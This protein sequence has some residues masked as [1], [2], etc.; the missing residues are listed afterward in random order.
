MCDTT[1]LRNW[2]YACLAAIFTAVA[3]IVGAAIANG[4]WWLT[5]L[6]PIGMVVAAA[7]TAGAVLLVG[8]AQSA[9]DALCKCTGPRCAGQCSNTSNTLAAA[10]VVLGIQA[11]ACLVVAAYAWVPGA[12]NPAQWVIIGALLIEAA[13][14][15]SAI[16]FLAAMISCATTVGAPPRGSGTGT[17]PT[18]VYGL[19]QNKLELTAFD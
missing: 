18:P 11:T 6:S 7:I 2:L 19:S 10:K 12:A 13:L 14:I 3:T 1:A 9:F 8:Q 16:A 15:T 17:A 5:Y 4:S